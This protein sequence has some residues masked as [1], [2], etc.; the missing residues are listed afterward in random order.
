MP[1]SLDPAAIGGRLRP[2]LPQELR[3]LQLDSEHFKFESFG[4]RSFNEILGL[5]VVNS[6]SNK[7]LK[8]SRN[9]VWCHDVQSHPENPR[10]VGPTGVTR[11]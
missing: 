2:I 9:P 1:M 3:E 11:L 7:S 8:D 10:Y 6:T 5:V 4:Q